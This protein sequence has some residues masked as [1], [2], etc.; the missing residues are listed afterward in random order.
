MSNPSVVFITD[1][2][3]TIIHSKHPEEPVVEWMVQT[4]MVNRPDLDERAVEEVVERRAVTHMTQQAQNQLAELLSNPR[5][6]FVPCTMRN[7]QQVE[8]ID[9]LKA[10]QPSFMICT[11]GAQIYRNGQL[12]LVWDAKMRALV[13]K[14]DV[15]RDQQLVESQQ[16]PPAE[17]RRT[18]EF[19]LTL[20]FEAETDAQVAV[21]VLKEV[22]PPRKRQVIQ[23][24]RKVFVIHPHIDKV[25]AVDYLMQDQAWE[26]EVYTAGDSIV[27]QWFTTRGQAILP[28]HATFKGSLSAVRTTQRGIRATEEI[29]A[30]LKQALK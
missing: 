9:F 29:L 26:E 10:Y 16:L 28:A 8:R 25:H 15:L 20:K 18:E 12:D 27:D 19:Y 3:R 23:V 1:L 17:I 7:K 5:F 13:S 21:G 14:E 4:K 30:Y 24:G 22:F 11:N 6:L 2:D